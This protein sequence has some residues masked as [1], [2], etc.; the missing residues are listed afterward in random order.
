MPSLSGGRWGESTEQNAPSSALGEPR[1]W[2]YSPWAHHIPVC[3]QLQEHIPVPRPT[4][5]TLCRYDLVRQVWCCLDSQRRK[6]RLTEGKGLQQRLQH[7]SRGWDW[8][9]GQVSSMVYVLSMVLR[10]RSCLVFQAEARGGHL[11]LQVLQRKGVFTLLIAGGVRTP[12]CAWHLA[13]LMVQG[14]VRRSARL[15]GPG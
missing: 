9:P 10:Q 3:L 4:L 14:G 12:P 2:A 5:S 11:A 15:S 6:L 13:Q 8:T 7:V 1:A